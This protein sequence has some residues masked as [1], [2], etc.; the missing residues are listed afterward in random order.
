MTESIH[1]L[2]FESY[3]VLFNKIKDWDS[4][5]YNHPDWFRYWDKFLFE[6]T[7]SEIASVFEKNDW[8]YVPGS[9]TDIS[10][11]MCA[12]FDIFTCL[13]QDNASL[14]CYYFSSMVANNSSLP[15]QERT[16]GNRYRAYIFLKDMKGWAYQCELTTSFKDINYYNGHLTDDFYD[17]SLLSDVYRAWRSRGALLDNLKD[18]VPRIMMKYPKYTKEKVLLEGEL[19]HNALFEGIRG[20]VEND[21]KNR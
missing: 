17:L 14:L 9:I 16:K 4:Y 21:D 13:K 3:M 20:V 18:Q 5:R 2:G 1:F 7:L 19:A 8:K 15:L 6:N 11:A 10:V 12:M